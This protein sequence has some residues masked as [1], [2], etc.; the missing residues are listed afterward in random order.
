MARLRDSVS[1]AGVALSLTLVT[2][3]AIHAQQIDSAIF[4]QLRYRH[5][6]PPGNRV[7]AVA[8]VPGQPNIYYVGAASGGI[9]E[10]TDGGIY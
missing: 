3:A 7:S 4:N 5:I 8:G 10:T 2:L 9:W 1:I 6:G